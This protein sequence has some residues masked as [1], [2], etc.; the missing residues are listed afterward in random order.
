M[1]AAIARTF[2][3]AGA[4]VY[5]NDLIAGRAQAVVDD[6]VA[7]GGQA[8]ALVFDVTS[9]A[10][11]G[12]AISTSG[13]VDILVNN[14]GNAGGDAWPSMVPFARS[15]PSDWAPYL[16]VNLDGVMNC[17]RACLPGMIEGSWG[18]VITIMSD[19]GRVGSPNMAAYAAAKAGAA[20]VTR[21]VAHEEARHGI[22][23]NNISLGTMRTP[24][25]EAVWADPDNA[26]GKALMA[27]YLVR[28]P[29][30]PNDVTALALLLASDDGEWIT[31]QTY[32]VNGGFSLAL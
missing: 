15:E 3:V 10:A 18:R 32:P 22:T 30:S 27:H 11:V 16:R 14:A 17:V 20:A 9:Y 8:A 23:A 28:R 1:G 4:F 19:A 25:T 6:I 13:P 21:S 5:V 24:L 31:G 29:G 26:T 2:A 12:D 7:S